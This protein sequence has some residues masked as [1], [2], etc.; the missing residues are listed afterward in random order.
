MARPAPNDYAAYYEPYVSKTKGESV[1]EL[2]RN[3]SQPLL[4]FYTSLPEDK[5]DYRYAEGKWSVKELLQH[6]IDADRIF[7]YRAHRISRKDQT[8]LPGFDENNFVAASNAAARSLQ[9]LKEEFAAVRKAT[10]I[11][12]DSLD[13]T[14]LAERGT[15]S[16]QTVTVNGLAYIIFGHLLHHKQVLEERYLISK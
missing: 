13:E 16:E 2:L 11:L 6:V 14:Q 3:Y 1:K 7:S 4:E 8:P 12:L 15:A 10:D 9:S 5:A